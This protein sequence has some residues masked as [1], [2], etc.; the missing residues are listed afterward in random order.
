MANRQN[1]IEQILRG[2]Q[3]AYSGTKGAMMNS[4]RGVRDELQG[5][6]QAKRQAGIDELTRE[7]QARPAAERRLQRAEYDKRTDARQGMKAAQYPRAMAE[8]DYSPNLIDRAM[9]LRQQIAA[10]NA[11]EGLKGDLSRGATA[12]GI[13]GGITA[14][15]AALI[16]LMQYLTQGSEVEGER[17]DVLSS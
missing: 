3:S 9:M 13:A 6:L 14:S 7:Y 1:L 12:A 8:A 15:G 16:D 5:R 2:A 4:E 17:E 10:N 11:A